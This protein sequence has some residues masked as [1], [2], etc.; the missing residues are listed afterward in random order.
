MYCKDEAVQ[1]KELGDWACLDVKHWK[2]CLF[3]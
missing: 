2:L 3:V 1:R